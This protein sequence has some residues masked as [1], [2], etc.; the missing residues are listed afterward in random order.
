LKSV[1]HIRDNWSVK[2]Q[3]Y[4]NS[5]PVEGAI[6]GISITDRGFINLIG[7]GYYS[8]IQISTTPTIDQTSAVFMAQ[9]KYPVPQKAE[10][11]NVS[12]VVLPGKSQI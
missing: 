4:Y 8:G 10:L 11:K 5:I 3:Q 6:I 12:L 2:F 9:S 7:S 1:K